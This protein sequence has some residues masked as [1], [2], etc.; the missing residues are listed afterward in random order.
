MQEDKFVYF[1]SNESGLFIVLPGVAN[2]TFEPSAPRKGEPRYGIAKIPVE[3]VKRIEAIKK[4]KQFGVSIFR[5]LTESEK[6]KIAEAEEAEK[7][8]NKLKSAIASGIMPYPDIEKLGANEIYAFANDIGV[9]VYVMVKGEE[10]KKT[11]AQLITEIYE[12]LGPKEPSDGSDA[13]NKKK[14]TE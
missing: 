13:K 1:K 9:S 3:D 14:K 6:Q 5:V 7:Y 4:H 11:K 12:K 2:V 10:S 8:V